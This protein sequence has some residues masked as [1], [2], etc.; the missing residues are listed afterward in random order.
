MAISKDLESSI[1]RDSAPQTHQRS[2]AS[3]LMWRRSVP[4]QH[5][6]FNFL[7]PQF[8]SKYF[9]PVMRLPAK[10]DPFVCHIMQ[11]WSVL[12]II[13]TITRSIQFSNSHFIF[14][15]FCNNITCTV[16]YWMNLFFQVYTRNQA[17]LYSLAWIMLEKQPYFICWK[18]T[19]WPN[20]FQ[21]SIQVCPFEIVLFT[22]T[23]RYFYRNIFQHS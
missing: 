15:V 11:P 1:L 9:L 19:E 23:K 7:G 18:M 13:N 21:H 8:L 20:M 22:S 6:V 17:S 4:W 14:L 16:N 10:S 12:T 5:K 2:Y 3:D